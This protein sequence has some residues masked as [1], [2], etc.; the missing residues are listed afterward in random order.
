MIVFLSFDTFLFLLVPSGFAPFA[1]L[2]SLTKI[3]P[4]ESFTTLPDA[5]YFT[6]HSRTRDIHTLY[7][8]EIEI[9]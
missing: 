6:R 9:N 5:R 1:L 4:R 8:F 3:R 2:H 7:A